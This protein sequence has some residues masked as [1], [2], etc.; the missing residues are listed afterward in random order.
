MTLPNIHIFW[1]GSRPNSKVIENLSKWNSKY[2]SILRFWSTK[3]AEYF[4]KY[5]VPPS[6]WPMAMVVDLYRVMAVRDF[7]G[8]YCD[9][10]SIPGDIEL[11]TSNKVLL[12]LEESKRFCNGFFFAPEGHPFL[13]HW[14]SEIESSTKM[15]SSS[16]ADVPSITGPYAL[17]RAIYTYALLHGNQI[18]KRDLASLPISFALFSRKNSNNKNA[19]RIRKKRGVVHFAEASWN[20]IKGV[21]SQTSYLS[22]TLY[23][24]RRSKLSFTIEI[25][26]HMV[27]NS[28]LLPTQRW[29]FYLLNNMDNRIIDRAKNWNSVSILIEDESYVWWAVSN[30]SIGRI[31]STNPKIQKQLNFAGWKEYRT[32]EWLRPRVTKLVGKY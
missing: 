2:G 31:T 1:I 26:R 4:D 29:K 18:S 22:S 19:D 3:D 13:N 23:Q 8:W 16:L 14:L 12:V 25:L 5:F 24:L 6:N 15:D 7:G 10:D 17:S 21:H 32:N 30:L 20:P 9:A 28:R 27:L 11:P